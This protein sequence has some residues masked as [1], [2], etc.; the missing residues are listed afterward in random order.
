SVSRN[1]SQTSPLEH[2]SRSGARARSG[3][4]FE[5]ARAV[6]AART[7]PRVTASADRS[8]SLQ[9][10]WNRRTAPSNPERQTRNL[11]PRTSNPEPRAQN[12]EPGTSNPE[13][14][15]RNLEPRTSNPEPRTRAT[16]SSCREEAGRR[17]S[18]PAWPT[19]VLP[20]RWPVGET[21]FTH[22]LRTNRADTRVASFR[23][24]QR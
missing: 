14:R 9:P 3:A 19:G 4:P 11:E 23:L 1:V 7:P 13:P 16:E 10:T 12:V 17:G 5:P 20:A 21:S 6:G 2:S 22:L 24:W 15:T 8:R 18:L